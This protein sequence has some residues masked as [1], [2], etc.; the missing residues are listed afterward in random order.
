MTSGAHLPARAY[1]AVAGSAPFRLII[2]SSVRS[3][4]YR[5][6][7]IRQDSACHVGLTITPPALTLE[8]LRRIMAAAIIRHNCMSSSGAKNLSPRPLRPIRF[9]P[10]NGL[11][12][13]IAASP[14]K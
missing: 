2:S 7:R 4:A 5:Q 1:P 6:Q 3:P 13:A 8:Q 10:S 11:F 9:A 14:M 12:K